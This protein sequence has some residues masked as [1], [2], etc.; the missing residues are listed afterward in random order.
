MANYPLFYITDG[1]IKVDFFSVKSPFRL[2]DWTPPVAR[3]KGDGTWQSSPFWDGRRLIAT[4]RENISDVLTIV[5]SGGDMDNTIDAVRKLRLLL[6]KAV[7]Y[8][9][10]EWQQEPVYLVSRGDCETNTRYAI[11][12]GYSTPNDNNP[13]QLPFGAGSSLNVMADFVL[14]IE[15]GLWQNVAPGTSQQVPIKGTDCWD[16][17]IIWNLMAVHRV[18]IAA[19]TQ[20][21][22][23]L[24]TMHSR[25]RHG[26]MLVVM[27]RTMKEEFLIR[28]VARLMDG[29]LILIL[30]LV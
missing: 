2:I 14:N 5:I 4:A 8:W 18:S 29:C 10:T 7:Y 20:V 22:T 23:I 13:F 11:I 6:E 27:E 30:H 17:R 12:K 16:F 21:L 1:D 15:H 26:F 9:T 24:L 3:L 28:P 19:V 25:R